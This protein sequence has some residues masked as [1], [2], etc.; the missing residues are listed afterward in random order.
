LEQT[1]TPNV[2]DQFRIQRMYYNT[3]KQT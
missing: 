1:N 2:L 3:M